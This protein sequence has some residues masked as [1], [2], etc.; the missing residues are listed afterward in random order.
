MA[1]NISTTG[2]D[3]DFPVAG[4]DNDSQGFRDNFANIKTNLNHAKTEI[5]DLQ[6]GVARK[7]EDNNFDG[8]TQSNMVLDITAT[9]TGI[10]KTVGSPGANFDYEDGNVQTL[11]LTADDSIALTNYPIA[12]Y[13]N[14]RFFLKNTSGS[15]WDIEFTT[16]DFV[17]AYTD[18]NDAWTDKSVT[19]ATATISI[20]DAFSP[21]G[22]DI[23]LRYVGTF[24]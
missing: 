17:N 20:I 24:S 12:N 10:A 4:R 9:K 23:Y 3:E 5:D 8:N 19:V 2:L 11:E 22:T 16:T 14:V 13:G 18:G 1:S 15:N 21:N 6:T 7:D